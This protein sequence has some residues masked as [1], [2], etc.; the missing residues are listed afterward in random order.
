LDEL[1]QPVS[2][3]HF[4]TVERKP[5]LVSFDGPG[6]SSTIYLRVKNDSAFPIPYHA[7]IRARGDR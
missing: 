4:E 7:E 3:E 5:G 2:H 6:H 1:G